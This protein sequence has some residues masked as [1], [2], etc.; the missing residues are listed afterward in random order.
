MELE[1]LEE[2]LESQEQQAEVFDLDPF[3][4]VVG[5]EGDESDSE[6]EDSDDEGDNL[7]DLSSD[8]GG[9]P[10]DDS[11]QEPVST[12]FQHIQEM[13]NKLDSILKIIFDHFNQTHA[14]SDPVLIPL[15]GTPTSRSNSPSLSTPTLE[16]PRPISPPTLEE[17]KARRR[18]QFHTLLAIFDRT[19]LRTFKSRYTQFIVFWYS[20]LDPEFADLF[21]GMLVSKALLEEDQPPVT[22]AAAA[23]YIASFVSRAQFVDRAGARRVVQVLCG[24]LRA[25]LDLFDAL[26]GAAGMGVGMGMNVA[27]HSVFYAVAQAV[28]LIFCFRWRDLLEDQDEVDEFAPQQGP[29]KKWMPELDV[30]QRVVTS[31]LN[32]LK[33]RRPS[34]YTPIRTQ[35]GKTTIPD[36]A[37]RIGLLVQRRHAVRARRTRDG[38]R[39]LLLDHGS[40][41]PLRLRAEY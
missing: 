35:L 26:S 20:S 21:Q 17:G 41:P 22:R 24:F 36:L 28:F 4:T 14:A 15:P 2:A 31:E 13:V 23:S 9:D 27:Q 7:S 10:D 1:E 38:L 11:D 34:S 29:P 40:E 19:I 16:T 25:R 3:D 18:A 32:P 33:V 6:G 12:D 5:Q 39:L 30:V 8:A 37:P